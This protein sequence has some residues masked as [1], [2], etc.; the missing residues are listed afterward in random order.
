MGSTDTQLDIGSSSKVKKDQIKDA[1]RA[2]PMALTTL[3]GGL[4]HMWLKS[5]SRVNV[6]VSWATVEDQL[7][8]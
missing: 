4:G 5:L 1:L 2:D 8:N 3:R 6:N 7:L